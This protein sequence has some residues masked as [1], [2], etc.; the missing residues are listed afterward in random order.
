ME[1]AYNLAIDINQR[2][3]ALKESL[4]IRI[5]VFETELEKDPSDLHEAWKRM[6]EKIKMTQPL[7]NGIHAEFDEEGYRTVL[8]TVRSITPPAPVASK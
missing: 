3:E 6:L 7:I 8:K 5:Q 2:I 4:K 1:S